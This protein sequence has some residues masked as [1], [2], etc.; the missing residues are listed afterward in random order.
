ML[1]EWVESIQFHS[2]NSIQ[3]IINIYNE[4]IITLTTKTNS[5]NQS[6]A[7]AAAV[8]LLL[9]FFNTGLYR[10][11]ENMPSYCICDEWMD[12]CDVK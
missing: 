7:E 8:Y 9:V 11:H 3:F 6:A 5:V 12:G 10:M 1:G 4:N 2:F